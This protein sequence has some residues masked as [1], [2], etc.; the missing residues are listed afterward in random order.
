MDV[1][2]VLIPAS[3]TDRENQPVTGLRKE[4]FHIFEDAIEQKIEAFSLDQ[5]PLSVGI[6]FDASAS[7]RN[8]LDPSLAAVDRFLNG[9]LPGDEFFLVQFNDVPELRIGFRTN[10][11]EIMGDL[12]HVAPQGWT[13]LFD[14]IVLAVHHMKSAKNP[15]R[16]LLIL[17]DGGDNNSRYSDG[18]IVSLLR[19]ADVRVF[20]LGIMEN[21]RFLKKICEETGGSLIVSHHLKDLPHD[22][23]LLNE[24]LRSQYL[25]GYYPPERLNDGKYHRVKIQ[26]AQHLDL[27]HL[28]T[29]WRHGYY[30][31]LGSIH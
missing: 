15:R 9:S 16:A 21:S 8:K 30:A 5:A 3:V 13:A 19:E 26:L 18:E 10:P 17:S 24:R 11:A 29:S 28:Y 7:M 31:P 6:V 23:E 25:L 20:A 12:T 27:K 1:K 22:M 4:D 2:M 14:A